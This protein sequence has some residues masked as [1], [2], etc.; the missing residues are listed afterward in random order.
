MTKD[1][2]LRVETHE[3]YVFRSVYAGSE[4]LRG[5]ITQPRLP[6]V[7][8][9]MV[10]DA[11]VDVLARIVNVMLLANTPPWRVLLRTIGAQVHAEI[12][13]RDVEHAMTERICRTLAQPTFVTETELLFRELQR[14]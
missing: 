3:L 11:D 1:H 7:A 2:E 6:S 9:R 14:T 4:G 12:E 13:L 5:G 10:A 8:I